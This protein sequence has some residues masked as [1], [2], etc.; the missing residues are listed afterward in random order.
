M[1]LAQGDTAVCLNS[2][3]TLLELS[4]T[5]AGKTTDPGVT[6][7]LL[8]DWHAARGQDDL[9]E[10]TYRDGL[11]L[12]RQTNWSVLADYHAQ[13]SR[14]YGGLF[15]LQLSQGRIAEAHQTFEDEMFQYNDL[16]LK[17]DEFA[18]RALLD[19]LEYLYQHQLPPDTLF[20]IDATD[21][22]LSAYNGE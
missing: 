9:A 19:G 17:P 7:R 14:L 3:Q 5:A 12:L 11:A 10:Q 8:G 22:S 2:L 6:Y 21:F 15:R 16:D 4:Q 1:L 18:L 13:A 20:N